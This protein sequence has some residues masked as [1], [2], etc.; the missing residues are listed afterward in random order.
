MIAET[1]TALAGAGAST[2]VSAMATDLWQGTREGV[3][4]VFGRH[5]PD[6]ETGVVALLDEDARTVGSADGNEVG[7]VRQELVPVW[8]RRMLALLTEH[9][10]AVEELRGLV[11]RTAPLLSGGQQRWVQTNI[12]YDSATQLAVQGGNIVYR[13]AGESRLAPD[14]PRPEDEA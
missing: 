1:L 6:R 7:A 14:A 3:A 9:P 5:S 4:R 13:Q 11:E 2:L 12:A 8:R 10:E